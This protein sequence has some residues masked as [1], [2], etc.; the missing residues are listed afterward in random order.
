MSKD[1]NDLKNSTDSGFFA[2]THFVSEASKIETEGNESGLLKKH[3]ART[4][5]IFIVEL[6]LTALIAYYMS[7]QPV[8]LEKVTSLLYVGAGI[9]LIIIIFGIFFL[10]N[11]ARRSESIVLSLFLTLVIIG[12]I[13]IPL[14]AIPYLY[15]PFIVYEALGAT[16]II[17]I[18]TAVYGLF[19][20]KDYTTWGGPLL[21][22]LIALVVMMIISNFIHNSWLTMGIL[23]ANIL[24]FTLYII[25]DNQMIKVEFL[26]KLRDQESDSVSSWWLLALSSSMNIYLDFINLFMSILRVLGNRD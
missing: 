10:L 13:A 2:K 11:R 22:A 14:G 12:V 15:D 3:V 18:T 20:K 1:L 4:Y 17:Y 6:L 16:S 23:L 24:I 5:G 21:G 26:A 25:Y 7:M 9:P 8:L 19:T